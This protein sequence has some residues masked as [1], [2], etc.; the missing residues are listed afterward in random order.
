MSDGVP[1]CFDKKMM[2]TTRVSDCLERTILPALFSRVVAC[3][4]DSS[5]P[6]YGLPFFS[7]ILIPDPKSKNHSFHN[8][9]EH[10][11]L[12]SVRIHYNRLVN[13]RPLFALL[14]PQ[15]C[16]IQQSR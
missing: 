4:L 8:K 1:E 10:P 5:G 7:R 3:P 12:L 14:S 9:L 16:H 13:S 2:A 15:G 6:L 11:R